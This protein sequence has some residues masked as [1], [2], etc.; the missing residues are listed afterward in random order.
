MQSTSTRWSINWIDVW[1]SVRTMLM[2]GVASI[3][4]YFIGN[5]LPGLTANIPAGYALILMPVVTGLTELARRWATN[6]LQ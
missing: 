6:Y 5:V 4:L 3:V 2:V 1:K